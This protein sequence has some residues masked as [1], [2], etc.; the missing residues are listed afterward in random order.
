MPRAATSPVRSRPPAR[1]GRRDGRA[2]SAGPRGW[3]ASPDV[4][5]FLANAPYGAVRGPFAF[6]ALRDPVLGPGDIREVGAEGDRLVIVAAPGARARIAAGTDGRPLV[7]TD[8]G[9]P[10]VLG[11]TFVAADASRGE[12][13]F[14][15]RDGAAADLAFELAGGGVDGGVAVEAVRRTGVVPPRTG[16][17]PKVVPDVFRRM[18]TGDFAR[19]PF[20][21]R[22]ETLLRVL[23]AAGGR[24][25]WTFISAKGERWSRHSARAPAAPARGPAPSHRTFR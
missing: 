6:A 5:L 22:S 7:A 13:T 14:Q 21:P 1:R 23:E 4:G 11:L 3:S 18:R 17:R 16:D 2:L 9:L 24:S 12:L 10:Q 20:R 25:M 19:D 15:G 8:Y